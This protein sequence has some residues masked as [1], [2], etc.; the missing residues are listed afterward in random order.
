MED[1]PIQTSGNTGQKTVLTKKDS[2]KK[3]NQGLRKVAESKW[4]SK[5]RPGM[6]LESEVGTCNEQSKNT[7]IYSVQKAQKDC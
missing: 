6:Q 4:T 1:P 2:R 3:S 7:D 5:M